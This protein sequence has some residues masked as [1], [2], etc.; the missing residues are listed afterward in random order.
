MAKINYVEGQKIGNLIFLNR[1]ESENKNRPIANF[2]CE[3]G[4]E[5]VSRIDV[6]K[7]FEKK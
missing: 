1:V 4:K 2:M 6:I 7:S 5:L 3:C